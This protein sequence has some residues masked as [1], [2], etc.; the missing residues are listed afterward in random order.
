[1]VEHVLPQDPHVTILVASVVTDHTVT[2]SS[3]FPTVRGRGKRKRPGPL[4]SLGVVFPLS[5]SCS[6]L[7]VWVQRPDW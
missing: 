6:N 5:N 3:G 7:I 1:M 2:F 4:V